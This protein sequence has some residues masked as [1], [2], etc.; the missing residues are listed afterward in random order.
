VI[1][2]IVAPVVLA[3]SSLFSSY[4]VL[5]LQLKAPFN[6]LF[7][8]ARTDDSYAVTGTLSY[9][10][11]GQRVTVDGVR[12]TLRGN[13][14]RRDSE[15][16]FPKLKVQFPDGN[17]PDAFGGLAS[18]KIGT[19]CG[20]APDDGVTVK[21]GRL[22]NEHSPVREV[23][24]YRLL[25]ALGVPSLK[26]RQAA[27]TYVYTDGKPGQTPPQDRPL[28]RQA[29]I[30]EDT[31]AAIKRFGGERGIDEKAFSNARAQFTAADTARL[32]LA[33]ALIGNFD[34]CLRMTPGDTYRCDARH[35]LWNVAVAVAASGAARPIMNDFDVAGIVT[36]HH[37]W[38]NDVFNAAFAPSK[39][40][41]ETEVLA[42]VQRTRT[43]FG[44]AELDAAR[45]EFVRR[46]TD[47]YRVLDEASLDAVGRTIARQYLD[48]FYRAIESDDAFYRPVVTATDARLYAT[49][50]RDVVCSAAG[51]I[52][53]G[54]PVSE[55]LQTRGTLMQVL[56]LDALWHWAPP[57]KCPAVHAGPVWIETSAVSRNYPNSAIK[58]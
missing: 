7:D 33:E 41:A 48:A 57:A 18:I 40:A 31:E 14:S 3:A 12:I 16:A 10:A 28:V 25:E 23:F 27:M 4:D 46:K 15:C 39:S 36:G 1:A 5:P 55:P 49:G 51:P 11:R 47:A 43:L 53:P 29:M 45:A 42:Q 20:E 19:H 22:P 9:D 24:V 58:N 13:T 26:A 50:N 52:P 34:W 54:T 21:F 56:I 2:R 38:F 17:R 30:V 8:R 37:P 35:P 32:T 6:D 44:R